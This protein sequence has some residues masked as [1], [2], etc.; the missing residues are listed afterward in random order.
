MGDGGIS[1][2]QSTEKSILGV[3]VSGDA[4]GSEGE[5]SFSLLGQVLIFY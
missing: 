4:L 1:I 5:V 3:P 2:Q